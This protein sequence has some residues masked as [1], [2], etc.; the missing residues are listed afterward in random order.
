MSTNDDLVTGWMD[1]AELAPKNFK[2]SFNK[3]IA[4]VAPITRWLEANGVTS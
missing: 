2:Q 3:L 4:H 1:R